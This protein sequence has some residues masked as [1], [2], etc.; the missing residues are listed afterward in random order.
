MKLLA[1][2]IWTTAFSFAADFN[3]RGTIAA[4]GHLE[5]KGVNGNVDGAMSDGA[6]VQVEADIVG[7]LKD[8]VRVEVVPR[9]ADVA[10][11]AVYPTKD[12]GESGCD[13]KGNI[14]GD[15]TKVHFRLK[16]PRGV[17][18]IAK[19]VNGNV[20]LQRLQSN[21]EAH[22]VNG[23]VQLETNESASAHTV[24]GPI[25]ASLGRLT[26]PVEFHTVNGTVSISLPRGSGANVSVSVVN[27]SIDSGLP[28]TV[29]GKV[30]PKSINGKIGG[31]GPELK[32][33][34]VNGSVNIR[35]NATI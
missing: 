12:G 26:Q 25:T 23:T 22:T 2:V 24:N 32:V 8:K 10:I 1:L 15:R 28:M 33:R 14:Q 9:G 3:W 30:S 18:L 21:V 16:L 29:T 6:E 34:T 19:T 17:P 13:G 5:I 4:G 27:G 11:C 20:N 35:E 7:P 31:G